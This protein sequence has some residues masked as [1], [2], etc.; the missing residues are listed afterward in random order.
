M[1]RWNPQKKA[2]QDIAYQDK[3]IT[4]KMF[5]EQLKGKSLQVYGVDTGRIRAVLPTNIPAVKAN[6][7]RLDNLLE[8]E[9]GTV[10]LVDYES[11]Y[12]REGKGKYLN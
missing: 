8:L 12:K 10:A 11:E 3:D 5:A 7:L 4:S 9:D 6:E 2:E 1:E